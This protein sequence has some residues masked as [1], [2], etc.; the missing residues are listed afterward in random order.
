MTLDFRGGTHAAQ[1]LAQA[2]EI[3][4]LT[5]GAPGDVVFVALDVEDHEKLDDVNRLMAHTI[6]DTPMEVPIVVVSQ[7]PP[8]WTR[9][10]TA[11]RPNIFYQQNTLIMSCALERA[12]NPDRFVVG[13]ADPKAILPPTY[14][15]YL[16]AF[17]CPVVRMSYE[18]AELSKL[19][20]NYLLAASIIA[21]NVLSN[22]GTIVGAD[23]DEMM[24]GLRL[25]KRIGADSYIRPGIIGGHLPRDIVTI[26]NLLESAVRRSHDTRH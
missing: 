2:A 19:A 12:L 13:C 11:L 22:V 4:G 26:N 25:D 6:D 8:G 18:S 21:A 9:P 1:T 7:V 15:D 14:E 10:W 3:R 16:L 5:L 24:P 20:V 17:D 23:W